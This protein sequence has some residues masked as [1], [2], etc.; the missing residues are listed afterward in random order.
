MTETTPLQHAARL[1]GLTFL[2]VGIAGFVPGIT[3]NLYDGLHFAGHTG[4]AELLGVFQVS[5]LHNIVHLLFGVIGLSLARRVD[6]ARAFL[7]VGGGTYLVLWLYG[8]IVSKTSDA[9]FVPV[10]SADDWLHF[11]LGVAMVGLG[12][13]LTRRRDATPSSARA[14]GGSGPGSPRQPSVG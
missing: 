3:T 12:V 13:A 8:I 10:N 6:G 4:D 2:A 14:A 5:V 9:N 11:G 1:V 7:L